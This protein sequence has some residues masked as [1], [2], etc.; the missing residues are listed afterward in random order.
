MK[1]N[2]VLK[3]DKQDIYHFQF[4]HLIQ[5][6]EYAMVVLC[7]ISGY[8]LQQYRLNILTDGI[9][10]IY[11]DDQV[12][13]HIEVHDDCIDA[14][15]YHDILKTKVKKYNEYLIYV[16]FQTYSKIYFNLYDEDKYHEIIQFY[17]QIK[18]N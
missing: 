10:N 3:K 14:I 11:A 12:I 2:I 18:K 9:S 7:A 6:E 4:S 8:F 17:N 5:K 1:N 13:C 15:V 16:G